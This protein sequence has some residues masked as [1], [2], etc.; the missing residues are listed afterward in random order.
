MTKHTAQ[1]ASV[2][3]VAMVGATVV[4]LL[5]GRS[6]E[7]VDVAAA[8]VPRALV[9][10]AVLCDVVRLVLLLVVSVVVLGVVVAVADDVAAMVLGAL[11]FVNVVPLVVLPVVL[12]SEVVINSVVFVVTLLLVV[13]GPVA[14]AVEIVVVAE[15]VVLGKHWPSGCGK[16]RS[17]GISISAP[18]VSA[19]AYESSRK[20]VP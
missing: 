3:P 15:V 11:A 19:P 6:P 16:Y 12:S 20:M 10:Y 14:V 17:S 2:V 8:V 4:L 5:L 13:L 1:L 7:V 9:V 18:P